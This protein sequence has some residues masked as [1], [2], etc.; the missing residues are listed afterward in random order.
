MESLDGNSDVLERL[1]VEM[2][3]RGLSVRD[4][5]DCFR[6]ATGKLLISK[7]AVSEI[8]D[9]LWEH[10]QA[11]CHRDLSEFDVCYLFLGSIYESLRRYGAKEGILA[12]WAITSDGR[13]VL[14][15]LGVENKES[16][17]CW[18]E[19]LRNMVARGL[20]VPSVTSDG[21]PGLVNAIAQ[22]FPASLRIRCWYHRMGNIRSKLPASTP[23]RCWRTCAQFETPLPMT[24]AV[25]WRHA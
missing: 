6:D 15:H 8:T 4:V 13:K 24:P 11:F 14:L 7:T 23:L 16:E 18:T 2:Y 3:A 10:Y 9:Q 1:V 17:A 5:E 25:P 20:G 12:A 21:A 22:V 19:F